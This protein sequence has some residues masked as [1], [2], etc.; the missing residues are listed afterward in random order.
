MTSIEWTQETWNPFVGCSI[1]SAGCKNCYAMKMAERLAN[2]GQES[3]RGTTKNWVWTG[4]LNRSTDATFYAPRKVRKPTTWFVNSMSDFWHA[5]ADDAWRAEA[6]DIMGTTPHHTY[7]VLTKRPELITPTLTRIGVEKLPDNLWLGC[8]V[9]DRRVVDRIDILR[10]VPARIRFLSVEPMTAALGQV[11]LSGIHW[12]ITGGE[13]GPKSR[14]IKAEWVREVRDQCI[15]AGV[16]YFHKQWGKA[17]WNPLATNAP[18][19]E[20]I[21]TYI[22]RV[23]PNGK[24]GA[25]L[26]GR[27]WREMPE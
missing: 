4:K 21:A 26:D 9:E 13:S 14:P 24:G 7:Q 11:D 1:V 2:M 15:A 23:D 16:A 22:K 18:L 10:T 17:E 20:S 27:L 5:N 3:Y 6:L 19:G 8:T 12:V 25:L